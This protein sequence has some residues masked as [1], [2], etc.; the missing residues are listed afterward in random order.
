MRLMKQ[1]KLLKLIQCALF[2]SF[3]FLIAGCAASNVDQ[4]Q[5]QA[6]HQ[7]VDKPNLLAPPIQNNYR[8]VNGNNPVVVKAFNHY[9]KTG[10]ASDIV[11]EGFIQYAYNQGQQPVISTT[12]Y[13]QT[14]I[15][16]QPGER[17][18]NVS[19]ADPQRWSY[20]VAYSGM[21]VDKRV[22]VL[23]TPAVPNISTN[24]VITTDR[25]LY[26]LKL[27]STLDSHYVRD[28]RFWYPEDMVNAWNDTAEQQ[29]NGVDVAAVPNIDLNHL[30]FDYAISSSGWHGPRWKP[31]RVFDDGK[32]TF[33]QM[34][35]TVSSRDLPTLFVVDG[36]NQE[37]V[38][39]RYK[40]P[41]FV[42]DKIFQRATLL[43]GVGSS[44]QRVL[45]TNKHY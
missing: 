28:V 23:V 31:S 19:T 20:S 2:F 5:Y 14:V 27:V 17:F 36:K 12:P 29:A 18:T 8:L 33:I 13:Q 40:A 34:P 16:L 22:N 25:R 32:Q 1:M 41:Y 37:L 39:Y 4:T 42:V 21:G 24:M 44:Q 30:N 10:K 35:Q 7:I 11:T 3:I 43:S 6:A 9:V 45:I 26:D 38:N 15:S